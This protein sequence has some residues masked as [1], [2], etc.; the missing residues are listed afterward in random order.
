MY[1][2]GGDIMEILNE[3]IYSTRKSVNDRIKIDNMTKDAK[4]FYFSIYSLYM[5]LFY[6]Y[7]V[8]KTNIIQ[9]DNQ[10][11]DNNFVPVEDIEKD[12]YQMFSNKFLKFFYIRNNLYIDRLSNVDID[13]LGNKLLKN[14]FNFG[15]EEEKFIERTY[16]KLIFENVTGDYNPNFNINFGPNNP[17]FYAPVNSL[18]VGI[19][20]DDELDDNYSDIS[21]EKKLTEISIIE[22]M[23]SEV[24]EKMSQ[25]LSVPVAI[26]HYN[27]DS[28]KKKSKLDNYRGK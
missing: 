5:D 17:K 12:F 21:I 26:I 14:N 9:Y 28:I 1:N 11:N 4:E 19:R 13:F 7:L 6:M 25:M 8:K 15:E 2:K 27:S 20:Y 16:K 24:S 3:E 18:V 22:K 23:I 10:L